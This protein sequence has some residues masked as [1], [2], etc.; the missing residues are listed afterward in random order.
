MRVIVEL[1][2][3]VPPMNRIFMRGTISGAVRLLRRAGTDDEEEPGEPV[4]FQKLRSCHGVLAVDRIDEPH[5]VAGAVQDRDEVPGPAWQQ[6][7]RDGGA[8]KDGGVCRLNLEIDVQ[9]TP[10]QRARQIPVLGPAARRERLARE[11]ALGGGVTEQVEN[12]RGAGGPTRRHRALQD[13][14]LVARVALVIEAN[15]I[16][17]RLEV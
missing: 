3:P 10:S 17:D 12:R 8:G 16:E 6:D 5:L 4:T 14:A 15:R 11:I 1:M 13:D 7:A 2:F 9:A